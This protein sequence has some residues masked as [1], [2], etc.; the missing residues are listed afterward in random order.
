MVEDTLAIPYKK[1]KKEM[2]EYLEWEEKLGEKYKNTAPDK[3]V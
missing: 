1:T 3:R 2:V